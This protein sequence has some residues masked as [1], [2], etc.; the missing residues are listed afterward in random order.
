MPGSLL[1]VDEICSL[2]AI[3]HSSPAGARLSAL[4]ITTFWN[5]RRNNG[6]RYLPGVTLVRGGLMSIRMG[7][8]PSLWRFENRMRPMALACNNALFVRGRMGLPEARRAMLIRMQ[9]RR[10]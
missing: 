6:A 9:A 7:K 1:V 5:G 8:L 10:H 4:R 2:E 3:T